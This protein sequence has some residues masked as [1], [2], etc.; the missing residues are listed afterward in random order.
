[1]SAVEKQ[2]EVGDRVQFD[3]KQ[4]RWLARA[5]SEDG[6]YTLLTSSKFGNV[7]YT[8]V[9]WQQGVRGAMN[10]IGGGL[11]IDTTSGL[12]EAIDE[13]MRMLR[14]DL[15]FAPGETSRPVDLTDL[16]GFEVSHR[17]RVPLDI[18]TVRPAAVTA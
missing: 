9:D 5:E 12:D 2:I 3:G 13:A 7:Y 11:D 8:I 14:P 16:R 15:P 6:R 4:T 10:V 17:N 18:T 1:M